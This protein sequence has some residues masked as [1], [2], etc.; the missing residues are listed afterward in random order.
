M[1]LFLRIISLFCFFSF[2]P[3]RWNSGRFGDRWGVGS[4]LE[5]YL[6]TIGFSMMLVILRGRVPKSLWEGLG[7]PLGGSQGAPWEPL[8]PLLGAFWANLGALW[9]VLRTSW[10]VLGASWA[11]LGA[12]WAVLEPLGPSLG[13]STHFRGAICGYRFFLRRTCS[14]FCWWDGYCFV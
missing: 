11:V 5:K 9:A 13:L 2:W 14:H 4:W 7:R 3:A 8:G 12:S 10:A 6:K 1:L